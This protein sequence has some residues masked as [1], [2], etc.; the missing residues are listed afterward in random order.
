MQKQLQLAYFLS[1]FLFWYMFKEYN[2]DQI[3]YKNLLFK[4][5]YQILYSI[6]PMSV[7]ILGILNAF[8]ATVYY[9]KVS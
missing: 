9:L 7:K 8:I 1:G 3:T 4:L 6:F 2:R 5:S